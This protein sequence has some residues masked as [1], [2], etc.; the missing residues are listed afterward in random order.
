MGTPEI[1][2]LVHQQ[3]D[4][5]DEHILGA[6]HALLNEYTKSRSSIEINDEQLAILRERKSRYLSGESR[7]VSWQ[8]VQDRVKKR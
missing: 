6:V 2:K 8:D 1:R 7:G 5:A 3:I 4:E